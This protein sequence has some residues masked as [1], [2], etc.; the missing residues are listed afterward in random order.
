M[1]Y[2]ILTVLFPFKP[3]KKKKRIVHRTY[4]ANNIA[5]NGVPTTENIFGEGGENS[6]FSFF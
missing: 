3:L 4:A 6:T 1:R 5:N 2:S